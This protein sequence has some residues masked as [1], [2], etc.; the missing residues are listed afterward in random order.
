M[1]VIHHIED[2]RDVL[3]GVQRPAFIPTMGNLHRG[4]LSLIQRAAGLGDCTVTSIFVN[5]LQFLPHEDFDRY[6]R[7]WEADCAALE[8]VGCDVLFAPS[9]ADLYP[10]PQTFR[11]RP[12][13]ALGDMLEGH[14]R[15][16]FFE[17]V[18]TVVMKLFMC[19]FFGKRQ[20]VTVF[21]LKDYQQFLI[22]K[23]LVRQ[24]AL[25]IEVV[26]GAIER[27]EDGLAL[28]SRNAYLSV[29]D[30]QRASLLY[31]CLTSVVKRFRA[32]QPSRRLDP[33]N[34]A[35]RLHFRAY[36]ESLEAEASQALLSAG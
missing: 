31:Q 28:S 22:V 8:S 7:T 34:E 26:G 33:N 18:S 24:F 16:G 14:F 23:R 4:H 21:G 1:K 25:P 15:P 36:V 5:R 20:G 35:D 12:D 32:E 10:Q 11:I 29:S 3:A 19:V 9:E 17:G 6:P 30:R 13:P 27:D 2:L